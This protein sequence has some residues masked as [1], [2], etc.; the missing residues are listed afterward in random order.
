MSYDADEQ[1]D[2]YDELQELQDAALEGDQEAIERSAE[3]LDEF[4]S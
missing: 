4:F 2:L 1:D 3:L